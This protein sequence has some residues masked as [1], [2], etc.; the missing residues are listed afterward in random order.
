MRKTARRPGQVTLE[1]ALSK[2]G[3]ASRTEGRKLIEAGSVRVD[4]R[5]ARNPGLWLNPERAKIEIAGR[6]VGAPAVTSPRYFILHKPR[7]VVT[8]R[9]DERGRPTIYSLLE[10]LGLHVVAAGRL[11]MASTGLLILTNDTK[12]AA[13]ITDPENRIPRVYLVTVTGE[14]TDERA[15]ELSEGVRDAGEWLRP[16]SLVVRKRSRR[17]SHLVVELC[18]GK[19]REIRRLMAS[20]G[21][22]VTALKRVSFGGLKLDDLAAGKWREVSREEIA[23]A[24]RG[25]PLR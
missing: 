10:G 14:V 24:F 6:E 1:R 8:T 22:E 11:D 7:G 20:A 25:A 15:A 12:F 2:L 19:N 17:E 5:V 16:E 3:L 23:G 21:H 9:S 18:E 4:G 13:W